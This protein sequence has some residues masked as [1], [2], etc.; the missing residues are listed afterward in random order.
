ML[1]ITSLF[2]GLATLALLGAMT[3]CA[4]PNFQSQATSGDSTFAVD[5]SNHPDNGR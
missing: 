5:Q 2:R 4:A 1:N 3:A